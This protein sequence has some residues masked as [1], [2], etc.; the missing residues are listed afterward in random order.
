MNHRSAPG[1]TNRH[2]GRHVGT[3][4]MICVEPN[5]L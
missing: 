1:E 5:I 2:P 3:V 4:M